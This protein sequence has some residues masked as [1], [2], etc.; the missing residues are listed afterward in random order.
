[1]QR[2]TLVCMLDGSVFQII[3]KGRMPT[4]RFE[5]SIDV[6]L[7][8]SSQVHYLFL[9]GFRPETPLLSETLWMEKGNDFSFQIMKFNTNPFKFVQ[10]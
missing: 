1:M 9:S 3:F 5:G 4:R 2:Q 6:H 10:M 7:P 8:T